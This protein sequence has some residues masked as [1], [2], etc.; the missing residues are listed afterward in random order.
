MANG[1]NGKFK[2]SSLNSPI[3]DQSK[4]SESNPISTFNLSLT[5]KQREAK[6]DMELP[7]FKAQQM[8]SACN[9]N[10]SSATIHYSLECDDDFDDEDPDMDLEI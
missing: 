10:T 8:N 9:T 3:E 6:N 1:A 2:F 4:S 5:D 7:Y